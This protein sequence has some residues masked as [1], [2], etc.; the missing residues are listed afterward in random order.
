MHPKILIALIS[1]EEKQQFEEALSD[2][3]DRGG[4]L[5]FAS[6]KDDGLQILKKEKPVL[7]FLDNQLVGPN[8]DEWVQK[9]TQ[10][11]LVRDVHDAEQQGE[12]FIDRP[13]KQEQ[14]LEKCK[15]T[16]DSLRFSRVPPM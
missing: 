3:L 13:L 9:G 5:L 8:E 6:T 12:D 16:L 1:Q 11:I 7:V 2:Y 14:I 10:V 15:K 4:E